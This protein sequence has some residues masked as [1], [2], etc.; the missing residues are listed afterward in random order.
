M[1]LA[2]IVPRP[3]PAAPIIP[4]PSLHRPALVNYWFHQLGSMVVWPNEALTDLE[5]QR[6]FA[7]PYKRENFNWLPALAPVDEGKPWTWANVA[8]EDAF[9]AAVENLK[10][11]IILRPLKDD[12]TN[13][14]GSNEDF[15]PLWDGFTA[16]GGQW[17]VDNDG[18]G[19]MDSV[20]VDV[21][22]PVRTMRDGR[23]YKPLAA[24]PLPRH[25]RTPKPK[26]PRLFGSG[27]GAG[28][29]RSAERW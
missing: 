5:K 27:G 21:G 12:H 2:S 10:R 11:R 16:G 3:A 8:D 17:D 14:T 1:L 28:H 4:I 6:A 15:N 26:R 13:F 22:L 9:K 25:G 23:Q 20:W 19:V 29:G 24:I 18:D 7:N